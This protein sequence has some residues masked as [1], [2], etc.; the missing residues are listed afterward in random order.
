M[1]HFVTDGQ[2]Q[3]ILSIKN[4][5]ERMKKLLIL[6]THSINTYAKD[7]Y[8]RYKRVLRLNDVDDLKQEIAIA[9]LGAIDRIKNTVIQTSLF[10]YVCQ[11]IRNACINIVRRELYKCN[12]INSLSNSLEYLY[13]HYPSVL[14]V[15]KNNVLKHLINQD[16]IDHI[17]EELT[18]DGKEVLIL[19]MSGVR[20]QQIAKELNTSRSS[21]YKYIKNS[22]YPVCK[23]FMV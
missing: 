21:V 22:I 1:K 8:R 16:S 18:D 11:I 6:L 17:F 7:Y 4:D 10:A 5:N 13:D 23:K 15:E 19:L 3:S 9:L 20:V 14:P 12:A 2:I